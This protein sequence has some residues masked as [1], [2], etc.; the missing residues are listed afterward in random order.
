MQASEMTKAPQPSGRGLLPPRIWRDSRP[1]TSAEML[2]FWSE[3]VEKVSAS[4]AWMYA[5]DG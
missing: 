2:G 1:L 3:V 5:K 4:L